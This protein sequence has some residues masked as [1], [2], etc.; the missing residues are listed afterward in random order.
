MP[1]DI[2]TWVSIINLVLECLFFIL[3]GIITVRTYVHAR[4][5]ILQP[6][7]TEVFKTQ[8]Q[9]LSSVLRLFVG[10]GE[11]ELRERFG[12]QKLLYINV[13]LLYDR[14]AS[15]FF[16]MEFDRDKRPYNP[17]DCPIQSAPVE[18]LEL[19]HN[20]ILPEKD[21]SETEKLDP[22]GRRAQ[23]QDYKHAE[24][25][26]PRE[27]WER[28]DELMKLLESPVLPKGCV[29]LL[30]DFLETVEENT[31]LVGQVLTECTAELPEKYPTIE[32]LERAAFAWIDNRYNDAFEKLK[33]KADSIVE[34]I[35]GYWSVDQL[36]EN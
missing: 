16:D 36:L 34:F 2:E 15:L 33:P 14:Y 32:S 23:W 21:D 4:K 10:R 11:V 12:L 30:E 31:S 8:L 1:A 6:I 7:R 17:R 19:A 28:R 26:I 3:I 35:R 9:E 27:Y 13:T 5:T 20:Y 18:L 25:V 22:Q 24:I 29:E